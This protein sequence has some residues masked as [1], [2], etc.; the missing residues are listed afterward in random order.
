MVCHA[1]AGGTEEHATC[2]GSVGDAA[3][4]ADYACGSVCLR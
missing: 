3:D 4:D 1:Y 2:V